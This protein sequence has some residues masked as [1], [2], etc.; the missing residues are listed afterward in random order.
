VAEVRIPRPLIAPLGRLLAVLRDIWIGAAGADGY[1]NYLAHLRAQHPDA[2]P[3]S[4]EQFAR[5]QIAERWE[6][7]RRCC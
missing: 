6:G 5:Q 4:R 1:R 3:L 2:P 7:V